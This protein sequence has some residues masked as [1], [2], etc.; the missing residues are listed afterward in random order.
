MDI[1]ALDENEVVFLGPR[2]RSSSMESD[3]VLVLMG[4]VE[5]ELDGEDDKLCD[6]V[7][8]DNPVC[9][10]ESLPLGEETDDADLIFPAI[11]LG[12]EVWN[13]DNEEEE[14]DDEI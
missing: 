4:V 6:N 14:N 10:G 11:G 9:S 3:R 2:R 7:L 1:S 5:R 13:C 12:C 8:T